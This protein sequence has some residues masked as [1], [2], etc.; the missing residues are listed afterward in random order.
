MDER[1]CESPGEGRL[2][3]GKWNRGPE[4]HS[5]YQAW[6]HRGGAG[7]EVVDSRVREK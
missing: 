7:E 2:E 6:G 1:A 4:K 5:G 3:A